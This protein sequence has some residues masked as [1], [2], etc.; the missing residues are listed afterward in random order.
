[1]QQCGR[2]QGDANHGNGIP[3]PQPFDESIAQQE[4]VQGDEQI[5][6][7]PDAQTESEH[8]KGSFVWRE[9]LAGIKPSLPDEPR[10]VN[11]QRRARSKAD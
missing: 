8:H 2:Q 3:Q 10:N 5:A 9:T 1:V 11:M 7:K 6:A 4:F